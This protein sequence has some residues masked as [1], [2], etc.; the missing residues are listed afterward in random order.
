[1]K[2]LREIGYAPA[3][4]YQCILNYFKPEVCPSC[5]DDPICLDQF[6]GAIDKKIIGIKHSSWDTSKSDDCITI[7]DDVVYFETPIDAATISA[8]DLEKRLSTL[9]TRY[10]IPKSMIDN[11]D[12]ST[13]ILEVNPT[14]TINKNDDGSWEIGHLGS[15]RLKSLVLED[16]SELAFTK[17]CSVKNVCKYQSSIITA[18]ITKESIEQAIETAGLTFEDSSSEE[19]TG[20]ASIITI[21]SKDD[22]SKLEMNGVNFIKCGG[23]KTVYYDDSI[24]GMTISKSTKRKRK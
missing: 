15:T 16:N 3:N 20:T 4:K 6:N 12:V 14:L 13:F 19:V 10:D 17:L 21:T 7:T 2:A 11:V 24:S 1:M 23:C 9:L 5:S 18:D 8:W 22:L